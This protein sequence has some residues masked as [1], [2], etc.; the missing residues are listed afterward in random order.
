M[1]KQ[2]LSVENSQRK[3][4]L[5]GIVEPWWPKNRSNG[6]DETWER[7]SSINKNPKDV[8]HRIITLD[9]TLDSFQ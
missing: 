3:M 8:M 7:A 4:R 2:M 1:N 9:V 6:G 5:P